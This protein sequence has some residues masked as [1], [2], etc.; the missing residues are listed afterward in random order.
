[1]NKR[2]DIDKLFRDALHNH[3]STPCPEVWNRIEEQLDEE[4]KV[5][6]I[7]SVSQYRMA[8]AKYAA[9]A[10]LLIGLTIS[11]FA[12]QNDGITTDQPLAQQDDKEPIQ[13]KQIADITPIQ[14]KIESVQENAP[15]PQYPASDIILAVE[16]PAKQTTGA[17]EIHTAEVAPLQEKHTPY[18][19]AVIEHIEYARVET[20][21][22][23][24]TVDNMESIEAPRFAGN[25]KSE[26]TT[27]MARL[28]EEDENLIAGTVGKTTRTVVGGLLNRVSDNISNITG[29]EVN[30]S[31]DDEGSLRI[32]FGNLLARNNKNRGNR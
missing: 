29:K 1:M 27:T 24:T 26:P 17:T 21:T 25:T 22:D 7:A 15:E 18:E 4:H 20:P 14:D 30:V 31:T 13:E 9:V 8:W 12:L 3:E 32:G 10:C 11:Y 5:V 16:Y 2:E 23:L 6:P 19:M 28:F